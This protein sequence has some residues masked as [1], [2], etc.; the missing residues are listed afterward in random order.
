MS[1]PLDRRGME[2]DRR[3][4]LRR[5]SRAAAVGVGT[6]AGLSPNI[7]ASTDGPVPAMRSPRNPF[8]HGSG[9]GGTE[10]GA[11]PAPSAAVV[12]LNRMGFGP[13]PGDVAAFNALGGSDGQRM[14]A[15]VAQQLDPDSIDDSALDARV[16]AGGFTTTNKTLVQLWQDH[17]VAD[18]PY[19]ERVRPLH[20]TESL[21]FLRAIF[22]RKQLVE[23]LAEFWHN[24]FSIYGHEFS[25]AP[26]WM[27]YDRDVIRA[28]LLGNFRDMLVAN[29]TSP[30]MLLYLD[31]YANSVDG[32]NENYA[33]ELMELHTM[34]A[35]N[36]LGVI[37]AD[38]V[39]T[40]G[41]V[42]IGFVDEDIFAATRALTGWTIRNRPWDDDFGN[43]G[44]FFYY[45]PWHDNDAKSFL[46]QD[47]PAN[48]AAMQDGLDLLD[49]LASHPG[50]GRFIA[51]KLCRRLLG[52]SPPDGLVASAAALF[53]AQK[54]HPEQLKQVVEHI[55]LAPEFRS[56]WGD[57]IKRPFEVV[58]S[59]LR[60][61]EGNFSFRLDDSETGTLMWLYSQTGHE[62]FDWKPPNGYPDF[63]TAWQ[64]TTPRVMSWR[65]CNWFVDNRDDSDVYLLDILGQTPPGVRSANALV[66]F[67]TDRV[68]GRPLEPSDRTELVEFM[69]QGFLPDLDLPLDSDEA[70]QT[71]LRA[72]VGLIF[73]SPEFLWR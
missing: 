12:A 46:G 39:P 51:R 67:W 50:T 15:Y 30:Q 29:A 42:P 62:L 31:N 65:I 44:E 3:A 2:A 53:T 70:I 5:A 72:L 55:L 20:E 59:A 27:H 36:Y 24:H 73:M 66:D 28:H 35:E 61:A 10:N 64:S 68:L 23:V 17:V 49:A 56:T 1:Q 7:G 16:A 54:D 48:Q 18:P 8:H 34:G 33:R 19:E 37:P 25:I 14:A 52:D 41:G 58:T 4:F 43:T 71:R 11:P 13:R 63:K 47:L 38:E 22:S 6:A 45:A 9:S 32:P 69:A 60:A 40:E 57:K 21:T 26:I